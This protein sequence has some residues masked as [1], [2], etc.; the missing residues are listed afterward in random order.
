VKATIQ[1]TNLPS[2]YKPVATTRLSSW[3]PPYSK[4]VFHPGTNL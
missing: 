1:K 2:R 4:P 3:R